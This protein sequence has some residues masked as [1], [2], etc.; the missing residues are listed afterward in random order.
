MPTG[1]SF[2]CPN[3]GA[4]LID[5]S[6]MNL[7]VCG[8]CHKEYEWKLEPGQKSVLIKGLKGLDEDKKIEHS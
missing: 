4:G 3:C 1:S 7:R 8:C 6:S 5:L 2:R